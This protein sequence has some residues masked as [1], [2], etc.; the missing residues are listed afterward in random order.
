MI[1]QWVVFL[2]A[3]SFFSS[4]LGEIRIHVKAEVKVSDKS[5]LVDYYVNYIMYN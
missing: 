3:P 1:F 2:Q 5:T 4:L